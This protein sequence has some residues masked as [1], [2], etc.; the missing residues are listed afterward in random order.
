MTT[1]EKLDAMAKKVVDDV[2]KNGKN[3]GAI[4]K[5]AG[6]DWEVWKCRG[7]YIALHGEQ[8]SIVPHTRDLQEALDFFQSLTS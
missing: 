3:T 5:V 6:V 1:Q 2:R 7:E 4:V 8:G